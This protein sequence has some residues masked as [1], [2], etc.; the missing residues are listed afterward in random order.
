[1]RSDLGENSE[2]ELG[3]DEYGPPL[4]LEIRAESR[5]GKTFLKIRRQTQREQKNEQLKQIV[6]DQKDRVS[7]E[8]GLTNKSEHKE[9]TLSK[10]G[11]HRTSNNPSGHGSPQPNHSKGT[12]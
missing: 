3:V 7:V 9:D 12:Q 6:P 8:R 11:F 10:T 1:M 4:G 5:R 2:T